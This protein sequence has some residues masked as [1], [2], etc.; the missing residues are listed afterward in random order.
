[1]GGALG[2]S[3]E[4]QETLYLNQVLKERVFP[5]EEQHVQR[6]RGPRV[7]ALPQGVC[8]LQCEASGGG[9]Q[10]GKQEGPEGLDI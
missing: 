7:T 2:L 8:I 3:V 9:R 4:P 1:M 10:A 6:Y 5:S